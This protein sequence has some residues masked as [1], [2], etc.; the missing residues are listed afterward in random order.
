MK[1]FL[2]VV[3][4]AALSA[5]VGSAEDRPAVVAPA[6][7]AKPVIIDG[8]PNTIVVGEATTAPPVIGYAPAQQ[9]TRR[10]LFGRLRNRNTGTPVYSAP[11]PVLTAPVT[12]TATPMPP[13]AAPTPMPM[14]GSRTGALP[15]TGAVIQASGS[16]PPGTYTTTDGT[17]VQVG[18]TQ[19]VMQS[20]SMSS[21]S[22]RR[23]LFGRLRSR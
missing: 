20:T 2:F 14:P 13:V 23:G 4:V 12:G 17:I 19:P 1:R 7:P 18:G 10:G 22:T 3:T 8:S 21:Q 16:L 15:M 9:P 6:A 11:A 5:C